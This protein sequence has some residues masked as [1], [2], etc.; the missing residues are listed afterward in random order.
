MTK[1]K[2][3]NKV[4]LLGFL[5]I[6]NF[7]LQAAGCEGQAVL[8][9]LG[10][11][12]PE[13]TDQRRSSSYLL[14]LDGQ[15]RLLV[16]TGPGSSV[17]FDQAGA[18]IQTLDWI[19]YTHLHVDHAADLPAF[20]KGSYFEPRSSNLPLFGPA[21]NHLM[22][23][24]TEYVTALFGVQG[25]YRYLSDYLIPQPS[26]QYL[27][28][29]HNLA[30]PWSLESDDG[31]IKITAVPVVHGPI[32]ALAWRIDVDE[33][34][35]LI[36]GDMAHSNDSFNQMLEGVDTFIAHHAIPE[37]ASRVA[38]RLHM[39]PSIIGELATQAKVGKLVLSH[40]MR[41]IEN[42]HKQSTKIIREKYSGPLIWAIDGMCLP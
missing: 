30:T 16:D 1:Y 13:I 3:H 23:S 39:P 22:P 8:Q 12:G 9:I 10:S 20:I 28:Q 37:N 4:W 35:W 25:A 42:N 5:L 17:A 15:A 6:F 11:G 27:I 33:K 24:M 18:K 36:S 21:G 32:P 34:S 19:L 29:A 14:W 26:S 7:D 2:R 41:R 31:K 40:R 38:H